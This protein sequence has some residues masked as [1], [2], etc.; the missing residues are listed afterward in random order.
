MTR[1]I[2]C[3]L[4]CLPMSQMM[5]QEVV[6]MSLKEAIG[7]AYEH[8][9]SISNAMLNIKDADEQIV[10]NRAFGLP[11]ISGEVNYQYYFQIPVSVLPEALEEV[12]KAGNGEWVDKLMKY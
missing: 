12:V 2:T 9:K 3:L 5:A 8:D 1:L 4:L 6:K 10:E 11:Q 7:Y